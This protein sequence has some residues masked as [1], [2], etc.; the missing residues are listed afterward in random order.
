MELSGVAASNGYAI[1]YAYVMRSRVQH[2]NKIVMGSREVDLEIKRFEAAVSQTK[3]ELNQLSNQL[4]LSSRE[5]EAEMVEA[6][7]EL[8]MDDEFYLRILHKISKDYLEV[9][10][11]VSETTNEIAARIQSLSDEYLCERS[12]DIRDI[13][14]RLMNCLL[15]T[16]EWVIEDINQ[17]RILI[18]EELT[19]SYSAQINPQIIVG[20]ATITGGIMAHSAIIARSLGIPFVVGL[21]ELLHQIEDGQLLILDGVEGKLI[22]EPSEA[23]IEYYTKLKRRFSGIGASKPNLPLLKSTAVTLDQHSVDLLANIS[24]VEGAREA[25]NLGAGGIGLFRTE[26]LYLNRP[27][28][29]SEAEQFEIYREVAMIFGKDAPIIIRTFDLGGDKQPDFYSFPQELNPLLGYRGIR[30]SLD[31][32]ALF[33]TQL[34]A[35]LK[36]S[37]YGQLKIMFPM[38]AVLAEWKA[39]ML[40]LAEVKD[41]LNTEGIDFNVNLEVGMM[42]EVTSAALN[43][44]QFAVEA[45]FFSIGTND[46]IQYLLEVDRSNTSVGYLDNGYNP[47]VLQ[48]IQDVIRTANK[49]QKWVS[50]CGNMAGDPTAASLFLGMGLQKLS[51][52]ANELS[53]VALRISQ[54]KYTELQ[55]YLT[56]ILKMSEAREVISFLENNS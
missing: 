45:D 40:I 53:A 36:A 43:V 21:G 20:C 51:M 48:L 56:E 26:F 7:L 19:T 46:L 47:A 38:I 4:K 44:E 27:A 55:N 22:V 13:C 34:R 16:A 15:G 49:H 10:T 54:I 14:K 33:K 28:P 41:E 1:G 39:A 11:A 3:S 17:Q 52:N 23:Q 32:I 18:T 8:L 42:I 5:S 35:I 37:P 31:Q 30:V 29:P 24:S 25:K 50:L 9:E 6:L 2:S 12:A